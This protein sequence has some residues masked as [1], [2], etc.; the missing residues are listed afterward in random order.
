MNTVKWN[1]KMSVFHAKNPS[2]AVKKKQIVAW[3]LQIQLL[4][5]FVHHIQFVCQSL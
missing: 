1:A 2:D 5:E 3:D 4:E